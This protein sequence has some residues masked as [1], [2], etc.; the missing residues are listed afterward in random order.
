MRR[1][2]IVRIINN[3]QRLISFFLGNENSPLSWVFR[4][5]ITGRNDLIL[6]PANS[7]MLVY[8][9]KKLSFIA[10]ALKRR[11][12]TRVE[13]VFIVQTPFRSRRL[14]G[15]HPPSISSRISDPKEL[16]RCS[17]PERYLHVYS[18]STKINYETIEIGKIPKISDVGAPV[19]FFS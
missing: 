13:T 5:F 10:F 1:K 14:I 6:I 2:K 18:P 17:S 9:L 7:P 15:L 11:R 16:S 19:G 12:K 8:I 4:K 3:E